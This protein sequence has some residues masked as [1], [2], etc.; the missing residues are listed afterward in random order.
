MGSIDNLAETHRLLHGYS[1]NV[2]VWMFNL[3]RGTFQ[4]ERIR[5]ESLNPTFLISIV[6]D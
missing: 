3:A 2:K 4:L 6:K 5:F 1:S